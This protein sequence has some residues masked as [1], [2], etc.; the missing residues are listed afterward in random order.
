[1]KHIGIAKPDTLVSIL[2]WVGVPLIGI[3]LICMFLYPWIFGHGNWGHVQGVWHSWQSLNVGML[4]FLSSVIAFNISR[5][6][7]NKQR[8]RNFIA[9]R[10]FLPDA[11]SELTEYFKSSSSLLTEAWQKVRKKSTKTPLQTQVPNL[12]E[13]YKEIFSRCIEFAEPDVGEHLAYILMRLQ[14]HR[15]RIND[16]SNSFKEDST[17]MV[18]PQNIITYLYRLS[19][20]QALINKI[21][22]FARG[23]EAFDGSD[24]VW[25]DYRNAYA[26]LDIWTD[27][28]DDLVGFTQRAIER[29]NT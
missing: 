8:E 4:A 2:N 3:Y 15:S 16:L 14:V 23:L 29:N 5:F 26:N 17:V 22:G 24:L 6:N 9:A 7:A 10:A 1:M 27:E 20:L 28:F 21:F 11:L 25:E 19:E 18:L 12:P 13:G